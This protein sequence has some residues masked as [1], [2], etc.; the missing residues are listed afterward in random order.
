ML[1][2]RWSFEI[3]FVGLNS[4]GNQA[5]KNN[6]FLIAI[7]IENQRDDLLCSEVIKHEQQQ[8]LQ[9]FREPRALT[10]RLFALLAKITVSARECIQVMLFY[11]LSS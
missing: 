11:T 10:G 3:I 8:Q 4:H 7:S 9:Q 5:R 1:L 6:Y 2:Q